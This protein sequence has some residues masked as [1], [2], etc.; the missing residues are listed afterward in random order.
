MSSRDLHRASRLDRSKGARNLLVRRNLRWG[1]HPAPSHVSSPLHRSSSAHAVPAA[2]GVWLT[3]VVGSQ[4]SA[5]HALPSS[6][7]SG[8]PDWQLPAPSHVSSPLHRSPS[9]HAVP[10]GTGVWLTPVAGS[11][12]SAVHGFPSSTT[13]GGPATHVPVALHVS[14][15]LQRSPSGH[16]VPSGT[17]V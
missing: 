5:V 7:T 2:T 6:T 9:A 17:G 3:P 1:G 8:V 4:L 15:P 13:G 11:Q 16:A 14:S 12:L 10:T